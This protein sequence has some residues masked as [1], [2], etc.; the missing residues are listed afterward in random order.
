MD[1]ERWSAL[2]HAFN[3]VVGLPPAERGTR[4]AALVSGDP[5]LGAELR[6]LLRAD[7]GADRR[8]APLECPPADPADAS[9]DSGREE[10]LR[11]PFGLAGRTISHFHVQQVLG[12]GG[13]GV[14]YQA[15][16]LRLGRTVALKF[17]L[18]QFG[19]DPAAKER[20]LL[21]ARA[22]SA[23]D[24]PHICTIHEA[25]ET[26]EGQLFLAMSCYSGETL[27]ERLRREG[28]LPVGEA[29]ELARQLLCGLGAAHAAGIVHRDIKPGNLMLTPE[30]TLKILDFG[31]A[32][33]RDLNLTGSGERPGT[34]AYMSPEQLGRESVDERSDLWSAGVVLYE[35]LTGRQPFGAGH[36]LSTVYRILFEE[37]AAPTSLRLEI[38][39]ELEVVV[40]R[41]LE[42]QPERRYASAAEVIEALADGEQASRSP[43]VVP[44]VGTLLLNTRLRICNLPAQPTPLIGRRRQI[45]EVRQFLERPELRLLTL[46]GPGGT[47]KTR[48][49]LQAAAELA[50]TF[51][52]GLYF[53]NLAPLTDAA[54]VPSAIAQVLGVTVSAARPPLDSLQEHLREK[55]VLLLLDNFEHLLAAASVVGELLGAAPGLKVLATSRI[56][57]HL[58]GEQEY[59]VPPLALP[60]PTRLPAPERLTQY[61]AVRLFLERAQAVKPDFSVSSE[62]APAVAEICHRLDG[63]PLAIELAAARIR[64]LSPQ[65]LLTRLQSWLKLLTGGARDLPQRQQ[66]LRGTLEWSY[67]LLD[68]V[69]K[70]LFRRL[71]VFLGGGT[72]EGIE[73][74]CYT[75]G[76]LKLDVLDG[77]TSLVEKNL[78]R[79]EESAEGEPR[80]VMLETI[81]EYASEKLQESGEA[82]QIGCRHA[83]FFLALA[84]EAEPYLSCADQ[85]RWFARL[86]R[87]H[88]NFR[89]AIRWALEHQ[90]AELAGRL[91]GAL[92]R[93]W[94]QHGHYR[95]GRQWLGE[96]LSSEPLALEVRAMTTRGAG[97]LAWRQGDLITAEPL[98]EESLRYDRKLNNVL[99]VAYGLNT[100]GCVALAKGHLERAEDLFRESLL[101]HQHR[102]EPGAGWVL[103]NLGT[104]AQQRGEYARAESLYHESL[105]LTRESAD[106]AT[107]RGPLLSLAKVALCRRNVQQASTLG[108]EGLQLSRDAGDWGLVVVFL[109]FLA[110]LASAAAEAV[111]A[112]RL[113]GAAEAQS[114]AIGIPLFCGDQGEFC[115]NERDLAQATAR[116]QL[117]ETTWQRAFQEGAAMTL[118]EAIAYALEEH[119]PTVKG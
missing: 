49:A 57:L 101:L 98:L 87:E 90:Q 21:E 51:A 94:D 32:K 31:L 109:A 111:H 50:D 84:E 106:P 119:E 15:E 27:R 6:R 59:P 30:G 71:A 13:M 86:H 38:P 88:D 17:L 81:H 64:I 78:L 75:E 40:F 92:W 107:A 11:D 18:P 77:V 112:A 66:S 5:T 37:P 41:L 54:L 63:L 48:L 105:A 114:A 93:F 39:T 3:E 108:Q 14:V 25:G 22:A 28:A 33:V 115:R 65:A 102:E 97:V 8:L 85:G 72:L 45:L 74:I 70:V 53:V 34:V 118:E 19:L 83:S 47:G 23:L 110:E 36:E 67:D 61:E 69:E 79:Q 80:F 10:P 89:S 29:V 82:E 7:A 100:L 60:D 55:H 2:K 117:A 104:L 20:F 96:V 95:E 62:N 91:A 113:F 103:H 1:A 76:E 42:K 26:E 58:R 35:M 43:L 12:A 44:P 46:T 52:D 16:D 99:K 9:S 4:L 73:A 68:E 116:A 24:H 56:P